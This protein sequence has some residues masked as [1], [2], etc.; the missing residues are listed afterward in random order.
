MPAKRK[1]SSRRAVKPRV[2]KGSR[3][4]FSFSLLANQK[5]FGFVLVAAFAVV[6][7]AAL[8]GGFAATNWKVYW[9][10][11]FN[12]ASVDTVRWKPYYSDYGS[13]NNEYQCHVPRNA[14]VGNGTIKITTKQ[15]TVD[16]PKGSGTVRKDYTSAFLGSRETGSYYP[17]YGKYEMRARLPH[18]QG[19]WPGFW[20]R[21]R[22]G[23]STAEVDVVELFH[24]Q[25]PGKVTQT[26]HFPN[27]IGSNTTKKSPPFET[28][29][30]G[31]GGWH[32]FGVEILPANNNSIKFTFFVDGNQTLT[33]TNTQTSSWINS[34]D[35]SAAWDIA[36][37]VSAGGRYVGDPLKDLGYLPNL[38]KCSLSYSAPTNGPSSCPTAGIHLAAL[39]SVM[40]VDWVRV[41][42]PDGTDV[43]PSPIPQPA[44]PNGVIPVLGNLRAEAGSRAVTISWDKSLDSRVDAY[45]LRYIRTDSVNKADGSKWVYP[46]RTAATQ[47]TL[48]NANFEAG[49]S[50]DFQ[51]RAVDEKGTSGSADDE[52]S[53]YTS[54]IVA[55][56][57]IVVSSPDSTPPSAPTSLTRSLAFDW[58]QLRYVL[59]VKWQPSTDDSTG[60]SGYS[61][62]RNDKLLGFTIKPEI[63]D[64]N[65]AAG[66]TYEYQVRAYDGAKNTSQPAAISTTTQCYLIWCSLK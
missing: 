36:L 53:S 60:I 27:S 5:V 55:T 58:A 7:V 32:T 66:V 63:N 37:N 54:T 62:T 17:L 19:L 1:S 57:R 38:N 61:V 44:P 11:D 47:L 46:G 52:Y 12:G 31:T 45:S 43:T 16:C 14:S 22:N 64:S 59:N 56:P 39:P 8:G 9:Q 10:D 20:L 29:I 26:L 24:N 3:L 4:P 41:S 48:E 33:Y 13:G 40:E 25:A 23:A 50:Y 30:K 28:A 6:G 21:H 34:V 51:V 49:S 2:T 65:L 15:E 42:V 18:G 35:K